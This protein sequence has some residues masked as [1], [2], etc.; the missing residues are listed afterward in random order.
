VPEDEFYGV[1]EHEVQE[2]VFE[3]EPTQE[4]VYVAEAGTYGDEQSLAEPDADEA[5][6]AQQRESPP[7]VQPAVEVS[8][9]ERAQVASAATESFSEAPVFDE[10]YEPGAVE[11]EAP[12]APP[13][14]RPL[15][16][17][18]S[19][20][21]MLLEYEPSPEPVVRAQAPVVRPQAPTPAPRSVPQPSAADLFEEQAITLDAEE[22]E[23]P[24][25]SSV[26]GH[27]RAFVPPPAAE[28]VSFADVAASIAP[29]GDLSRGK[30]PSMA[31]AV[32]VPTDMV[33]QIAQRVVG[34]LTEK[35]IREVAWEILPD[36]A[37]AL[38]KKEIARLTA[39]LKER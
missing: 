30:G 27:A 19:I 3:P 28:E 18:E 31:A 32:P 1:V 37:E 4:S 34:Q 35:V 13:P 23:L 39:E 25:R 36:L 10:I 9:D 2:P 22:V 26:G 12:A 6:K 24:A 15:A 8:W 7:W 16:E 17:P 29:K 33:A 38:I 20:P 14:P 11:I 5:G 21:P